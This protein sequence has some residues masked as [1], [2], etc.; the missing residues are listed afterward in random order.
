VEHENAASRP[1]R[2]LSLSVRTR[3]VTVITIVTT[4]G[5]L[6]VGVSVYLVERHRILE[7]V[8]DR[9]SANLESAR[10]LIET[11]PDERGAWTSSTAA[12]TAV[13]ERMSPDDNTG[14]LGMAEGRI[15]T[16]PGVELDLALDGEHDFAAHVERTRHDDGPTIGT[17]AEAGVVWRY[18]AAPIAVPGSP[19]PSEVVFVMVYDVEAELGEFNAAARA[20]IIASVAVVAVVAA[21]GTLVATRLLRPLRHMREIAER[22]SERSLDERIP[23]VGNDDVADLAETMNRMLDRLDS[24]LDS[25]RQLLS[26]VGHEL[27]TPITIVRGHVE[28]MDPENP[29]DARDTQALAADELERMSQ[30]IEDLSAAAALHGPRP[31]QTAPV[32]VADL[33]VQIERKASALSGAHVRLGSIAQGVVDLDAGRITQAMLQLVQNAL[34][35]GGGQIEIGSRTIPGRLELWVRDYGPGVPDHVK[36]RIFE[37]FTRGA[38]AQTRTGSGL[39]LSIVRV[40]ARA[41]G[42]DIRVVDAEGGGALFIITV[43]RTDDAADSSIFVSPQNKGD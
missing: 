16:V 36:Q 3:I 20:F 32:D 31:V 34:T 37:R 19:D 10:Y 22:V 35:H 27:K 38:D 7:Q 4:L 12:L 5:L 6:A 41:H 24:A 42:G 25:Q 11:G 18:L 28:L 13:V 30:L 1:R 9:L 43:P 8:D 26:D 40:I 33:V 17:Y 2:G 23:A 21:A 39:G 14:A 15:T 29:T